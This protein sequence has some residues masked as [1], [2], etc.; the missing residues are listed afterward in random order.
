MHLKSLCNN[1][2]R[3]WFPSILNN[4]NFSGKCPVQ[5]SLYYLKGLELETDLLP[6]LMFS[7]EYRLQLIGYLVDSTQGLKTSLCTVNSL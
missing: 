7:G 2:Y 3:K 5:P 4:D 1:I 6:V